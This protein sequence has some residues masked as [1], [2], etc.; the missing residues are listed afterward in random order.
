[1]KGIIDIVHRRII[2]MVYRGIFGLV[3]GGIFCILTVCKGIYVIVYIGNIKVR[4]D[5][6]SV[7]DLDPISFKI[8]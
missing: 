7:R 4:G 6:G 5:D 1:M 8:Q 2:G 3:Y